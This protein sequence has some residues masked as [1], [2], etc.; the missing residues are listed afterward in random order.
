MKT[1]VV[2]I[3][4]S[5]VRP[6]L[7]AD[8]Q[9]IVVWQGAMRWPRNSTPFERHETLEIA[10]GRAIRAQAKHRDEEKSR[11]PGFA[12]SYGY[13]QVRGGW[14]LHKDVAVHNDYFDGTFD[15]AVQVAVSAGRIRCKL[16]SLSLDWNASLA[17]RLLDVT[18]L[19]RR[20]I[21]DIVERKA[22]DMLNQQID[23]AIAQ[24]A[25][26][27][28]QRLPGASAI[29]KGVTLA[30]LPGEIML[31]MQYEEKAAPRFALVSRKASGA[32]GKRAAASVAPAAKRASQA[33]PTRLAAVSK[34]AKATRKP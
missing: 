18:G 12:A 13:M 25:R 21:I 8:G 1:H 32:I 26:E 6:L 20:F 34:R 3:P 29:A 33:A 15:A 9:R 30:V 19:I 23:A 5:R 2:K 27:L 31:A 16:L 17:A 14:A 24:V 22:T 4:F 28:Q 10:F 11:L 7:P